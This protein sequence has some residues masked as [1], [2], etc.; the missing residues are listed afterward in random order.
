MQQNHITAADLSGYAR[1]NSFGWRRIPVVTG[2]VPHDGVKCQRT[3]DAERSRTPPAKR[4]PKQAWPLSSGIFERAGA[5]FKLR[6][7]FTTAGEDKVRMCKRVVGDD[8]PGFH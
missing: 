5:A 6:A 7:R 4:R 1:D 8:V 3:R 2:D